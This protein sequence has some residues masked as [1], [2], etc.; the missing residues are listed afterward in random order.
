MTRDSKISLSTKTLY[1]T[2]SIA[3]G[4]RDTAFNVFLLFYYTQVVGLSETLAGA[5]I[6]CALYL[7]T[8][9]PFYECL[10]HSNGGGFL[11]FVQPAGRWRAN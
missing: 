6:F 11:L 4:V 9:P 1:G 10:S 3:T 7:G 2:G 5:A 8:T